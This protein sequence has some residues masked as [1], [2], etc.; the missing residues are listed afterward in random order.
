M[1]KELMRD[2][3]DALRACGFAALMS[4]CATGG[5]GSPS[6]SVSPEA[7]RA[8]CD[9]VVAKI[10]K[11][12][13]LMVEAEPTRLSGAMPRV[14]PARRDR[15]FTVS[16]V[17]DTAGKPVLRTFSVSSHV[18]SRFRTEMRKSVATWKYQP[19]WLEGCPVPRR[20]S[21]TINVGG[22]RSAPGSRSP[23]AASGSSPSAVSSP[24][25]PQPSSPPALP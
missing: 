17:V 21:H 14:M 10:A 18:G 16:F 22:S 15:P 24:P 23:D 2:A 7:A 12:P 8:R 6:A 20:V 9:T 25:A 11:Y 19:A 5:G 4:G 13:K 3:H 1:R